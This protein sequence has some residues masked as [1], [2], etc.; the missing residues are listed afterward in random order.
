MK[1]LQL[2]QILI[3]YCHQQTISKMKYS[4][5]FS[6]F[7]I[8]FTSCIVEIELDAPYINIKNISEYET[9]EIVQ[10]I[11]SDGILIYEEFYYRS[12]LDI[13]FQNTGGF[14]ASSVWAE[15]I[16][17]DGHREIQSVKIYL[18]DIRPGNTYTYSLN[19]GFESMFDYSDYEVNTYWE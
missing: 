9:K 5:I 13:E 6:L 10:E 4:I 11:W 14:K 8:T 19:T 17:Y 16:F 3:L 7:I 15:V 12:W 18:P 1:D 2:A